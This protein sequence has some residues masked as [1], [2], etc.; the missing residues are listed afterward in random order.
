MILF[1]LSFKFLISSF[2]ALTPAGHFAGTVFLLG[3][4][5]YPLFCLLKILK[6]PLRRARAAR[7]PLLSGP[8]ESRQR[9]AQG[10]FTPLANPRTK[11][12]VLDA[13]LWETPQVSL[14]YPDWPNSSPLARLELRCRWGRPRARARSPRLPHLHRF[15]LGGFA[16]LAP[17]VPRLGTFAGHARLGGLRPPGPPRS[18]LGNVRRS[19]A[20]AHGTT[21][22]CGFCSESLRKS[23]RKLLPQRG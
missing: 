23:A 9:Q 17:H 5:C 12:G 3:A 22:R 16:P 11:V 13:P 14:R 21:S 4:F 6:F 15:G 19:C 18:P 7:G 2:D 1:T 20:Y 10:S 8:A